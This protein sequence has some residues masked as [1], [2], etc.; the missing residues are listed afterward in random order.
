MICK[1][2]A[3][4]EIKRYAAKTGE[5]FEPLVDDE[6]VWVAQRVPITI[7]FEPGLAF[8]D[9]YLTRIALVTA[10]NFRFSDLRAMKLRRHETVEILYA[11]QTA[12]ANQRYEAAKREMDEE[13]KDLAMHHFNKALGNVRLGAR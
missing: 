5:P 1:Q 13:V 7:P 4:R 2:R 9:H 3:I 11:M 6:G 10:P 12:L 8:R